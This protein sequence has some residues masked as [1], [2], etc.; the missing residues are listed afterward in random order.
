MRDDSLITYREMKEKFLSRIRNRNTKLLYGRSL[1]R[2]VKHLY[3]YAPG[4]H[5]LTGSWRD[6]R[7]VAEDWAFTLTVTIKP[8]SARSMLSGV[9]AFYSW[10]MKEEYV[11][12]EKN[13][14]KDIPLW[15][16]EPP[17][18]MRFP[19]EALADSFERCLFKDATSG[20]LVNRR[21]WL[22]FR[23]LSEGGFRA[24]ELCNVKLEDVELVSGKTR[25]TNGKGGRART[26]MV[27]A[28]TGKFLAEFVADYS[29]EDEDYIFMPRYMYAWASEK[30]RL[31]TSGVKP[32]SVD[33]LSNMLRDSAIRHNYTDKEVDKLKRPHGF[34]HLW[35]VRHVEAN[36]HYSSLMLMAGW[37][38]MAMLLKYISHAA[39]G[40]KAIE[41]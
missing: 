5:P 32:I 14:A 30:K 9:S 29:L 6:L 3:K 35:A 7:D 37:R 33:I 39:P 25:I 8:A 38:S 15:D 28:E 36:T 18:E 17:K 10:L 16:D 21:N 31:K 23:F 4:L 34:R 22:M 1:E 24:S 26:T 20:S 2:Y 27:L 13:P 41:R 12:F 19:D 40:M 11:E